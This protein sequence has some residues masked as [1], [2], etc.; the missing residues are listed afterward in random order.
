MRPRNG[1]VVLAFVCLVLVSG[2]A[3]PLAQGQAPYSP[4]HLDDA[5]KPQA[6]QQ[7]ALN[8]VL[9]GQFGIGVCTFLADGSRNE[10]AP[11]RHHRCGQIL[12]T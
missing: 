4:V 1:S 11:V 6:A 12:D 3:G 8:V 2:T 7:Q 10:L 5:G 9:V